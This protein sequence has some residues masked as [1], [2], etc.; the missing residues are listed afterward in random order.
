MQL[1]LSWIS[2]GCIW[3]SRGSLVMQLDLSWMLCGAHWIS[4]IPAINWISGIP[5][6]TGSLDYRAGIWNTHWISGTLPSA[7]HRQPPSA[8]H[9]WMPCGAHWISWISRGWHWISLCVR[10]GRERVVKGWSGGKREGIRTKYCGACARLVREKTTR[11]RV[12][13]RRRGAHLTNRVL[14][15]RFEFLRR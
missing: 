12:G 10:T 4:G 2:R 13:E 9:T 5:G 14:V 6:I 7:R 3:I 1:D 11:G 8:R 15:C